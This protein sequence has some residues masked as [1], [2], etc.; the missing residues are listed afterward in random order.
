MGWSEQMFCVQTET[1]FLGV[2]FQIFLFEKGNTDTV[3]Q[4]FI[5]PLK[6]MKFYQPE[7]FEGK[8]IL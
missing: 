7:V 4:E 1:L 3:L 5:F 8:D 2:L 6:L